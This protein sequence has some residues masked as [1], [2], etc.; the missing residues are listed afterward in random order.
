[1]TNCLAPLATRATISF[2]F[3]SLLVTEWVR[4][5]MHD[6]NFTFADPLR[7]MYDQDYTVQRA[8]ERICR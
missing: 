4:R 5:I 7:E 8:V 6:P 3:W 2:G 1:M